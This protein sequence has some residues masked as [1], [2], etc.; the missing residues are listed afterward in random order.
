MLAILY[1]DPGRHCL[2]ELVRASGAG[3]DAIQRGLARLT[4]PRVW[5][6]RAH[7]TLL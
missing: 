5:L 4:E 6:E 7:P 3:T 2:S 1:G